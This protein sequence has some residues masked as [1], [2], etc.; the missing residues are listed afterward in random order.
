MTIEMGVEKPIIRS[1]AQPSEKTAKL[2]SGFRR[3]TLDELRAADALWRLATAD[4]PA[5]YRGA[6]EGPKSSARLDDERVAWAGALIGI[7]RNLPPDVSAVIRRAMAMDRGRPRY[8][9]PEIARELGLSLRT[10]E[11][12]LSTGLQMVELQ[13]A[14]RI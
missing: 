13:F 2:R 14:T 4:R 1:G 3:R 9:M 10:A 12:K 5:G 8:T 6:L 11:R 7:V